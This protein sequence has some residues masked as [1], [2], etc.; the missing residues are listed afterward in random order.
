MKEDR[1]FL[2]L[3]HL[4]QLAGLVLPSAGSLIV[5]L[6]L[7]MSKKDEIYDLD[8][9]GKDIVNF[10]LSMFIYSLVSLVLLIVGIGFIMLL[11]IWFISILFPVINAIN[12]NNGKPYS[13]PLTIQ[14]LK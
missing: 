9:Q 11:V 12:V 7:W 10:Q 8:R 3:T 2:M 6:V 13:Y 5:P 4:S 14:L 1:Q